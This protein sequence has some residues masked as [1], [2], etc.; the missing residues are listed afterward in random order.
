MNKALPVSHTIDASAMLLTCECEADP[1][2]KFIPLI[3]RMKLDLAGVR[4]SL[5]DWQTLSLEQRMGLISSASDNDVSL[6]K[7][8]LMSMLK[9]IGSVTDY[10]VSEVPTGSAE[11][12]ESAE[13]ET[14]EKFRKLAQFEVD[15]H[16]RWKGDDMYAVIDRVV[17]K[18][19]RQVIKH[20]EKLVDH[21]QQDG[22][23]KSQLQTDIISNDEP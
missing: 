19:D 11:W 2:F 3:V 9:K 8:A 4:I 13:P 5:D 22:G 16:A 21:H 17:D 14:V 23:L 1:N 7:Y 6:F 15:W 20:K 18:L 12:L 10:T